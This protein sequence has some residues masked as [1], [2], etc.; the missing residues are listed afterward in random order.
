MREPKRSSGGRI[1]AIAAKVRRSIDGEGLKARVLR[2][3]ALMGAGSAV[4]QGLRF[5][6]NIILTRLLMPEA[7]GIMTIILAVNAALEALT[8]VGLREAIVQHPHADTKPFLNAAWWFAICRGIA[9]FALGYVFAPALV[10][11]YHI[12]QVCH[13]MTLSFSAILFNGAMST[14][15]FILL[16]EMRYGRWVE[17]MQGAAL[18]GVGITIALVLLLRDVRAL[19]YG[20]MAEAVLRCALSYIICPFKPGLEF[21]KNQTREIFR[22]ARGMVGSPFLTFLFL[23]AD[24]FVL[25]KMVNKHDLG[26]Y[27]MASSF[28]GVPALL[29]SIFVNPILMPAFAQIRNQYERINNA[30]LKATA[31]MSFV[32]FPL[33]MWV[34]L[35]GPG[36]MG[37]VYGP[38]YASVGHV[39]AILFC[40]TVLR[41]MAS[42]ISAV[43]LSLGQPG[44]NRIF[45]AIRTC[46]VVVIIYPSVVVFGLKG[47]AAAGALAM[48]FAWVIQVRRMRILTRLAMKS[49][50]SSV[51]AGSLSAGIVGGV[52]VAVIAAG[53]N[54]L[55]ALCVVGLVSVV[56]A[57]AGAVSTLRDFYAPRRAVQENA[58]GYEKPRPVVSNHHET[59][60][61]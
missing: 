20:Y 59:L 8:D 54:T 16:K 41:T 46:I 60:D 57:V 2:G 25:G 49:Y 58:S 23:Q 1:N 42:P 9:L 4:E 47:A 21:E 61:I 31:T 45:T 38:S 28:S 26:L 48:I 22:F 37:T 17:I 24:I 50:W 33:C 15:A 13:L 56:L 12:P 29:I 30:L 10:Q 53:G 32:G 18:G 6:R 55:S 40:A 52:G 51:I 5:I 43:Y 34:A 27:S 19:V 11:F 3:G 39:F 35:F 14:R 36:L 7:L 44:L